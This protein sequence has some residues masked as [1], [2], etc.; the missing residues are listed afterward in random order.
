VI[1]NPSDFV[2]SALGESESNTKAILATTVGKVLIIDEAYMLYAGGDGV[3]KVNDPY[4]TAVIDTLVAE[5]QANPGEDRCVLLL[6]YED[7]MVS[8]FQNVNPGLQRRFAL[9]DAF[10]FQDFTNAQ[11]R[12]IL[13]LKLKQ[14]DLDATEEAKDVV[15][16]MLGRARMKPNFGNGGE[17]ENRLSVAKTR[18]QQRQSKK[19]SAERSI[20]VVFEPVDFDPN[21]ARGESAALNC[22]KLFEDVVGC[23]DIIA[24]LEGY[25]QT[26]VNAKAAGIPL[27]ELIPTNFLFK[28]PPGTGKTT[29]ARKMGRVYYDMG[30]LS[31]DKVVECSA[32]DLV[33]EYVGQTGPKTQKQLEKGLGQ[34]LFI[35]E[36]YRL[37]EGH[38][39]AEAVNELVDILTKP[40]FL[41]KIVVILAGYDNDINRLLKMNPGLPSRFPEEVVFTNMAPEDCVQVMK[42]DLA[43]RKIKADWLDSETAAYGE[44]LDIVEKLSVL[45]SWGNARDMKTLAKK[46]IGLVFKKPR[47]GSAPSLLAQEGLD[48][49]RQLLAEREARANVAP[50]PMP[51]GIPPAQMLPPRGAPAPPAT[52]TKRATR[53]KPPAKKEE[54]KP[55]APAASDRDPGVSDAVWTQLQ[56]DRAAEVQRAH[57]AQAEIKKKEQEAKKQQALEKAR[58]KELAELAA[59]KAKDDAELQELKRRQEAA[60]LAQ[61]NARIAREKAL[62][63]LEAAREAERKRQQEEAKAQQKLR[64]MGVCPA[65]FQ[66]VKEAG[67]YRC[68]G[69]SHFVS[70]AALGL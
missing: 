58:E 14:Q 27:H 20:D 19:P 23:E 3:G 53:Q 15:C 33:A 46:M 63:E 2:G 9:E 64:S 41:G 8:M 17:V 56:A 29:T 55:P 52:P 38:F 16:E 66:W 18:F 42:R 32:S 28:G 59:K 51:F 54:S 44:L 25:Q 68:T 35:D 39:G 57:R 49:A 67:G 31:S 40:K 6:G 45:D 69:G 13:E 10:H 65:G 21:F 5:V 62:R 61:L 34:V 12:A 43:A 26:A 30:F 50:S 36:A 48:C 24:K 37:T 1:K 7:Q 70:N 4:K 22:R 47:D 11:L 60:R